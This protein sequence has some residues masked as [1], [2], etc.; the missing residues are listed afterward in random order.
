MA[1]KRT[2]LIVEDDADIR[3]ALREVLKEEG[4]VI[5]E[6]SNGSEALEVLN[7]IHG[8]CLILLDLMMPGMNG[9]DFMA[10]M[11]SGSRT[12]IQIPVVAITGK[13]VSEAP[14][15]VAELVKKPFDLEELF[16]ILRQYCEPAAA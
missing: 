11:K 5:Y 14:A 16:K 1:Q 3:E 6:A 8:A 13:P 12:F 15:G 7:K 4:Y 2:V 10:A 9:F